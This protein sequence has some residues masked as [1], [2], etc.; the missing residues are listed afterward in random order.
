MRL[1]RTTNHRIRFVVLIESG[2][3]SPPLLNLAIRTEETIVAKLRNG[4]V[5]EVIRTFVRRQGR[6]DFS[7]VQESFMGSQVCPS[8]YRYRPLLTVRGIARGK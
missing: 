5:L 1:D 7:F 2:I 6:R 8:T 4:L 3:R